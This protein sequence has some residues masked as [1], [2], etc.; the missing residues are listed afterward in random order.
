VFDG[1]VSLRISVSATP[2]H[3]ASA[4]HAGDGVEAKLDWAHAERLAEGSSLA[5]AAAAEG[6]DPA[7]LRSVHLPPGTSQRFGMSVAPGNTGPIVDFVHAALGDGVDPEWLTVHT[8]RRFDYRAHVERLTQLTALTGHALAVENTPDASPYHTPEDLAALAVLAE[9]VPRLDDIS[10]LVDTAHVPADRRAF[11]VDG[12]AVEAVL[13]R[14]DDPLRE[15]LA[16]PL[17]ETLARHYA[18]VR[19]DD[20]ADPALGGAPPERGSPWCPAAV[21]LAAVGP[22]RLGAIHLNDP[23]DDGLPGTGPGDPDGLDWVLA[24]CRRHDVPV[25]LEP[26][27]AD[28]EQ[29]TATV[30]ALRALLD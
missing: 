7:Q 26:G 1:D 28:P 23:T 2:G 12:A 25:V 5:A 16:A 20:G 9:R 10:V 17:R 3:L 24:Y 11:A 6:V 22:A 4:A 14:L 13:D 8:T 29:V 18:E 27:T 30:A 21:T 15:R 19:E